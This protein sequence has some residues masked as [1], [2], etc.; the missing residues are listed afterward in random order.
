[1][2][3]NQSKFILFLLLFVFAFSLTS[4]SVFANEK[5]LETSYPGIGGEEGLSSDPTLP[6]YV[7]YIFRV[8]LIIV[9]LSSF[10]VLIY[11]G[12]VFLTSGGSPVARNEG[13]N[14][15]FSGILGLIIALCSYLILNT[16][17]PDILKIRLGDL[18]ESDATTP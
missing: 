14:W 11:G 12:F 2:K 6:E 13:K 7:K 18:I 16:I 3:L 17:N 10:A 4:H 5:G 15:L 9:V 1:M 8:S